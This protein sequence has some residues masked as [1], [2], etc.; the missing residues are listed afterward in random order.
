[1]KGQKSF[2]Q[3]KHEQEMKERSA[4]AKKRKAELA[5]KDS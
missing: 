3:H 4:N 1:M 2:K 5:R